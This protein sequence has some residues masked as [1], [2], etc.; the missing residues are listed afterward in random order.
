MSEAEE[1]AEPLVVM[2]ADISGS[3][4]LYD[5]LGDAR[6]KRLVTQCLDLLSDIV[7]RHGGEV[8]T[9][10]GDEVMCCFSAADAAAAA[11]CDMHVSLKEAVDTGAIEAQEIKVKI[12]MHQ[13]AVLRARRD[14]VGEAVDI[15]RHVAKM[16]KPD[17]TL[18]TREMVEGFPPIYRALTRPVC[19][20]PW[21]GRASYL[22]VHE[23][24]WEV[25]GLTAHAGPSGAR[26]ESA[27]P[28]VALNYANEEYA[29]EPAH[30][31]ISIGRGPHNDII[32]NYDLVS[33]QHLQL[34]YRGGRAV[35]IDNSTNGSLVAND[36]GEE[37]VVHR[38]VQALSGKGAIYF[39]SPSETDRRYAVF[40]DCA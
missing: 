19:E 38:T 17:E 36:R 21:E 22:S 30:P 6:A 7:V 31:V 3:T 40:Y 23:L 39:G 11:A 4:R 29:L 10:I 34:A 12:G 27:M 33:R 18:T 35:L 13:G 16:A 24:V 9:T 20:E 1:R 37:T 28:R 32:V 2:F 26:P 8:V 14:L 5:T 15:A 25:E